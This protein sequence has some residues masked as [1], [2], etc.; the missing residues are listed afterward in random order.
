MLATPTIAANL[1]VPASLEALLSRSASRH[2]QTAR[3]QRLHAAALMEC[4]LKGYANLKITDVAAR[5]KVSTAS[6]YKTYEDR[7]GLLVAAI[8]T[9]LGILA[10]DVIELSPDLEPIKQVEHLLIAHGEV[11]AQPLSTWLFRLYAALS[12]S[13][14]TRL[15]ETGLQ[16]FKGI[17]AFWHGFLNK[18]VADGHLSDCN[19]ADIV[20]HLLGSIERC[21]ILWQLGCGD[22]D[23]RSQILEDTARHGAQ[24]LFN[25][26]GKQAS[27][28][29]AYVGDMPKIDLAALSV[30]AAPPLPTVSERLADKLAVHERYNPPEETRAR[31]MLAAAVVADEFGY[32]GAG[33]Q[34]VADLAKVSTATLYK[35]FTDKAD[36]F[37][38]A[39]EAEFALKVAF[40]TI[41]STPVHP[42]IALAR[43]V[44]AIGT[45]A[46]DP[47]WV[48][49]YHLMMASEISGT[50]RLVAL[51]QRHRSAAEAMLRPII[52][53]MSAPHPS[54]RGLC[55]DEI[56]LSINFCLGAIERSGIFSLILFGE[57]AVELDR[58]A[59]CASAAA[60]YHMDQM[61]LLA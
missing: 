25:R 6:I 8:E 44:F 7:D 23:K 57:G 55:E 58:L 61:A 18:L 42:Q 4:A 56:A 28:R 59:Q 12:W 31:I 60:T 50:P 39:I 21:T 47:Q 19:P 35:F 24:M 53:S 26:W 51:A 52:A 41:E 3:L 13:G 17:D 22:A 11:Y 46:A 10:G 37:S 45:R 36:L 38:T 40:D 5:A 30:S 16:I 27:G 32:Q 34:N 54:N 15:R 48:W 33:M 1:L 2:D 49:M 29:R 43:G 9:L 14:H 20:P